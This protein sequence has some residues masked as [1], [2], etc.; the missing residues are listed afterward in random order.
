M[1]HLR[2][3]ERQKCSHT[4]LDMIIDQ[5]NT[6]LTGGAAI[7]ALRLHRGLLRSGVD[8]TLWHGQ[9]AAQC[10]EPGVRSTPWPQPAASTREGVRRGCDEAWRAVS[11]RIERE[12]YRRGR[13]RRAGGFL[14]VRLA[15]RTP[16]LPGVFQGD[17]IHL[18]WINR[19]LDHESFFATVPERIPVVWTLHDMTPLTGGCGHAEDCL[20]YTEACGDCPLLARGGSTDLSFKQLAIKQRAITGVRLHIVTPSR[21]MADKVRRS[22]LMRHVEVDIIRNPIDTHKFSPRDKREARRALGVPLEARCVLHVA[23]SLTSKAKGCDEFLGTLARLRDV[24]GLLGLAGGRGAIDTTSIGVPVRSLG[25]LNDTE[26][27][28]LAYSAADVFVMPSHVENLPQTIVEALACGTPTVA[29]S[30]GGIP[31]LLQEGQTGFTVPLR[32]VEQMA[33]RVRWLLD[34]PEERQRMG[35]EGTSLIHRDY[36]SDKTVREYIG[37]Y[38]RLAGTA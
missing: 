6:M 27:L 14:P 20:G 29:F 21:W 25:Y 35:H 13:R 11:L 38:E 32:D 30:V 28:Q 5:F 36:E 22:S 34:H 31:E 2:E 3:S 15:R 26:Q 33:N 7:A 16:W 10:S 12:Y 4:C 23:H 17:V 1:E 18:H 24:P 9:S 37:L 19:L 8:S